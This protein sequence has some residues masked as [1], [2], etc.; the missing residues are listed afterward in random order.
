MADGVQDYGRPP[1]SAEPRTAK[2]ERASAAGTFLPLTHAPA[3]GSAASA[4]GAGGYDSARGTALLEAF[5]EARLWG[6][7]AARAGAVYTSGDQR[8][9]PSVGG[10]V[11]LLRE[12]EHGADAS[13]GVFYRPEGLTEPEGELEAV[14][15]GARHL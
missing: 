13:V 9:R 15:A 1:T 12:G 2:V 11:Q 14:L 5:A 10:R 8:L 4:A 7:I 6:P 3:L